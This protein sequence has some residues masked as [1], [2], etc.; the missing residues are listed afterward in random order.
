MNNDEKSVFSPSPQDY[1]GPFS[2]WTSIQQN[3]QKP[4]QPP[5]AYPG[6]GA[7][8]AYGIEKFVEGIRKGRIAKFAQQEQQKN[9]QWQNFRGFVNDLYQDPDLNEAA[10]RE[11]SSTF[12][13]TYGEAGKSEMEDAAK[14]SKGKG[15]KGSDSSDPKNKHAILQHVA[16]TLFDGMTGGK[17][18]S[19]GGPNF[20]EVQ[21]DLHAKFYNPDGSI[22]PEYSKTK[23]LSEITQKYGEA[24]KGASTE[25]QQ[26]Q[27][28]AS[29]FP[30]LV[31]QFAGNVREAAE[32]QKSILPTLPKAGSQ[33]DIMQQWGRIGQPATG[34]PAAPPPSPQNNST[35][36]RGPASRPATPVPLGT[37][38]GPP[39]SP[40]V[41]SANPAAG[42]A[43]AATPP[44]APYGKVLSPAEMYIS[45]IA[46]MA[47]P[48]EQLEYDGPDGRPVRVRGR[49][50]ILPSGA[51]YYDASGRQ[52]PI[53]PSRIRKGTTTEPR[54]PRAPTTEERVSEEAAEAYRAH[55]KMN[56]GTPL[57]G[58]QTEDAIAE[59]KARMA[60]A[61]R[62]PAA[63]RQESAATI[64]AGRKVKAMEAISK[65]IEQTPMPADMSATQFA[66]YLRQHIEQYYK[67]DNAV[68][69]YSAEIYNWINEEARKGTFKDPGAL[70]ALIQGA[71]GQAR[72]E[73]QAAKTQDKIDNLSQQVQSN[74]DEIMG[75]QGGGAPQTAEDYLSSVNQ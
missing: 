1:S 29:L 10:K 69:P 27:A 48:L 18:P 70:K 73:H 51:G 50:I 53:D 4:I 72:Q 46:G 60:S 14:G 38:I 67:N 56:P 11:I 64:E 62:R 42:P 37:L 75:G 8:I 6:K 36:Q 41:Q 40:A 28:V 12:Y 52:I 55:H 65:V 13:R 59:W 39:A 16:S 2:K 47:E 9:Q 5:P 43:S 22:K 30:N 57:D 23:S 68:S 54:Q 19:K 71:T 35:S 33:E 20:A 3:E 58:A 45:Q 31:S 21:R 25:Q 63:S 34:S 15:K 26:Q 74:I 66:E 44:T 17:P 61:T 7:A 24:A 49:E 32:Y